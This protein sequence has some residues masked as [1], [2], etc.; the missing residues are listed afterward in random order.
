MHGHLN[1]KFGIKQTYIFCH[2]PVILAISHKC[3]H[4]FLYTPRSNTGTEEVQ[5]HAFVTS[6]L[7]G[8][9]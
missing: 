4:I 9:E 7:D 1:V 2:V 8:S 5:I 3:K 6:V